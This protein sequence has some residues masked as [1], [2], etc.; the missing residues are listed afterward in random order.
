MGRN[1]RALASSWPADWD[2]ARVV[3]YI[4]WAEKVVADCRSAGTYVRRRGDGRARRDP[5]TRGLKEAD[6]TPGELFI[7]DGGDHPQCRPQYGRAFH[8][9][10]RR[11]A[12]P[13]QPSSGANIMNRLAV[14]LRSYS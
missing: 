9:Q 11:S 5:N 2:V 6:M 4:D 12:D 13:D 1:V 8:H 3:E 14:P 7:K 10:H